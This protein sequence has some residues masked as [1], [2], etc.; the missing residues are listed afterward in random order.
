VQTTHSLGSGPTC[1]VARRPVTAFLLL[2]LPL[3]GTN[4]LIPL[5]H[6]HPIGTLTLLGAL[7]SGL[8]GGSIAISALVGGRAHHPG[9]HAARQ[10]LGGARVVRFRADPPHGPSW[11]ARRIAADRTGVLRH[12]L[13]LGVRRTRPPPYQ[14]RLRRR[15]LHDP[16]CTCPSIPVPDRHGAVPDERKRPGRRASARV[17]ERCRRDGR[18]A[19]R[20]PTHPRRR[21]ALGHPRRRTRTTRTDPRRS[22]G[23]TTPQ[24]KRVTRTIASTTLIS[25]VHSVSW[26]S[27]PTRREISAPVRQATP[28]ASANSSCVGW[29]KVATLRNAPSFS[30]CSTSCSR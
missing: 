12:P 19:E 1:L 21:H 15:I 3:A 9:Q 24:P 8:V 7:L 25:L 22:F 14:H 23:G 4:M 11:A 26:R 29:H 2:T 27:S 13:A 16:R 18:G 17:V 28:T 30:T 20:L 10:P 5:A 6:G